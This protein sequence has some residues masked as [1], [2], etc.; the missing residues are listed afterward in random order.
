MVISSCCFEENARNCFEVRAARAARLFFTIRPTK[1]LISCVVISSIYTSDGSSDK[2]ADDLSLCLMHSLFKFIT[3]EFFEKGWPKGLSTSQVNLIQ[4]IVTNVHEIFLTVR[5]ACT[6]RLFFLIRPIK[7]FIC[8]VTI[9]PIY[10]TDVSSFK[11]NHLPSI[12]RDK[13]GDDFSLYPIV[14]LNLSLTN[15]R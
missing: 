9:W 6:S 1:F 8:G 15:F 5:A 11:T 14:H 7:F 13:L 2:L 10:T 12:M 3:D 4:R